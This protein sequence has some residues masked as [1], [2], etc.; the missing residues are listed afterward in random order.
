MNLVST[1]IFRSWV[2]EVQALTLQISKAWFPKWFLKDEIKRLIFLV[3]V[4]SQYLEH[5]GSR[6]P[7]EE[8]ATIV[9]RQAELVLQKR[10]LVSFVNLYQR[11]QRRQR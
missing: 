9:L 5:A 3:G 1:S 11:R 4:G 7:D 10:K 2:S 8:L 6:L